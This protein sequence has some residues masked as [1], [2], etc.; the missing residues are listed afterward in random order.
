MELRFKS[1]NGWHIYGWMIHNLDLNSTERDIYAIIFG[2]SQDADSMFFGGLKYL[3]QGLK[4]SKNTAINMLKKLVEKDLIIKI[5]EMKNGVT[6]NY[7]QANPKY[8]GEIDSL[9]FLGKN[10]NNSESEVNENDG[11]GANFA[12]P[13]QNEEELVSEEFDRGVQNLVGGGANFAPRGENFGHTKENINNNFNDKNKE[14][15]KILKN[16]IQPSLSDIS[17]F[18]KK[19]NLKNVSA[20]S[21]FNFYQGNGWMVGKNKMKN[22]ENQIKAWESRELQKNGVTPAA[23]NIVVQKETQ[24]RKQLEENYKKKIFAFG[25][26]LKTNATVLEHARIIFNKECNHPFEF[27]SQAVY[28]QINYYLT[29]V[30]NNVHTLAD[31]WLDLSYVNFENSFMKWFLKQKHG[32]DLFSETPNSFHRKPQLQ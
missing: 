15:G 5:T 2:F 6:F 22:W 3:E 28:N 29:H 20:D 14:R 32:S 10:V 17:D 11:G 26:Q 25:E 12:P 27:N 4:I 1:K 8:S 9:K 13:Y 21:F 7:Y 19:E 30:S 31:D 16:F 23:K 24:E 18:I